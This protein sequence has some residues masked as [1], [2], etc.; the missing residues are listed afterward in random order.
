M[1]MAAA[2]YMVTYTEAGHDAGKHDGADD[3]A[4]A[5]PRGSQAVARRAD[6]RLVQ[7]GRVERHHHGVQV[8]AELVED[9]RDD[10]HDERGGR[11]VGD[12]EDG[13]AQA[14]DEERLLTSELLGRP[15]GE[16][17]CRDPAQ[18]ADGH[19]PGGLHHVE[20]LLDEDGGESRGQA[21]VAE[22]G[23]EPHEEAQHGDLQVL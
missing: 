8:L 2:M 19:E 6:G 18:Y 11:A 14:C 7:L 16:E 22:H 20:A 1:T 10:E 17:P 15:A 23:D 9:A 3:G 13:R 4:H 21:V 5:P 12:A